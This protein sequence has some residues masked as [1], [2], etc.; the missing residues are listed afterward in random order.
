MSE[1]VQIPLPR[2][3]SPNLEL[4]LREKKVLSRVNYE[5]WQLIMLLF[6]FFFVYFTTMHRIAT[7]DAQKMGR[8]VTSMKASFSS[9]MFARPLQA[10]SGK[11]VEL[12]PSR[13]V[14]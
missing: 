6:V 11:E 2:G 3:I 13:H 5:R 10:R 8:M 4:E 14:E 1:Q 12:C 9:P 7:V